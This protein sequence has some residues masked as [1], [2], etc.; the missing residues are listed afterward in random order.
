M[1]TFSMLASA[2]EFQPAKFNENV[3]ADPMFNFGVIY[4]IFRLII[5]TVL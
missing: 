4:F 1:L 2:C 3:R 5:L